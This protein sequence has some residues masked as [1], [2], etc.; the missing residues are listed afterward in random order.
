MQGVRYYFRYSP[1]MG[2]AGALIISL[3][4]GFK[5]FPV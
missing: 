5:N 1:G 3:Q 4:Y 2:K